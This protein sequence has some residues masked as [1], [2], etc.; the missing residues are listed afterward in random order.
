MI[1]FTTKLFLILAAT[2]LPT[3]VWGEDVQVDNTVKFGTLTDGK[4]TLVGGNTY[5]LIENITTAGYIYVPSDAAVTINLGNYHIDRGLYSEDAVANGFVI[6][7]EGTLTITGTNYV[8]I[9]GGN[10]N[11]DGGAINNTGTLTITGSVCILY[12]KSTGNG[13]G[14]SNT[15][16]VSLTNTLINNNF[17]A[18]GGG[19]YNENTLT[20]SEGEIH[21]NTATTQGG[22]IYHKTGTLDI[23]GE[24]NIYGNYVSPYTANNVYLCSGQKITITNNL[25]VGPSHRLGVTMEDVTGVFTTGLNTYGSAGL[26]TSDDSRLLS[27]ASG[28]EAKL[29]T[30]WM[31]LQEKLDAGDVILA[32]NYEYVAGI[33]NSYLTVSENRTLNLGSYKINRKLTSAITDGYVIKVTGGTLTITGTGQITG[34]NNNGNG[35]GIHIADG[36]TLLFSGGNITGNTAAN[37]GG[38]YNANSGTLNIQGG[39]I[40][41]NTATGLGG[42]VYVHASGSINMQGAPTITGNTVNSAANNVYLPTG[43]TITVDGTLSGEGKVGVTTQAVASSGTLLTSGLSTRGSYAKFSSDLDNTKYEVADKNGEAQVQTMWT[44]LQTLLTAEGEVTLTK[45]YTAIDGI[46]GPLSVTGTVTLNLNSHTINRNLSSAVTNG[47]VITNSGDLTIT[48]SGTIRGGYND[49]N[50]GGIINNGTLTI[51]GGT[52]S[53]NKASGTGGGIYHNGTAFNLS[54]NPTINGNTVNSSANNV[55]LEGAKTINISG[56]IT[57]G[58]VYI[59]YNN[60]SES[61]IFTTNLNN[62]SHHFFADVTDFGIG[63]N[64]SGEAIVGKKFTVNKSITNLGYIKFR[65]S[66]NVPSINAVQGEVVKFYLDQ[67]AAEHVPYTL[68]Y[69]PNGSTQITVPGGSYP[70]YNTDYEFDMPAQDVTITARF[71]IGWYCGDETNPHTLNDMKWVIDNGTLR[72]VTKDSDPYA[73]KAYGAGSAPWNGYNYT[74]VYLPKNITTI[75]P[76]AFCDQTRALT[77]FEVEDGGSYF[78]AVGD[79]LFSYDEGTLYCYPSGK[80][81]A[82]TYEVP[83]GVTTIA[84]GAFAYN[85]TL[86]GITVAG[87]NTSLYA[88]DGILY[89]NAKNILYC[90]PAGKI[91]TT[92]TVPLSGGYNVT[93]IKPYAFAGNSNLSFIYLLHENVP[94][95]GD[96]MFD[97]MSSSL[98][99]MVKAG[100]KTGEGKYSNTPPWSG[101]ISR[102]YELTLANAAVALSYYSVD[103]DGA[104]KT[105]G[106]TSVTSGAGDGLTLIKDTDFD[107]TYESN[108]NVGTATVRMTGINNYAGTETTKTF[109]ITRQVVINVSGDYATY[110]AAEDLQKPNNNFTISVITGVNWAD[111][112]LTTEAIDYIPREVPVIL[113]RSHSD[114][115]GTYHLEAATSTPAVTYDD[116]HFKGVL[117]PTAFTTLKPDATVRGI[118]TLKGNYFYQAT[119]GTL[120]ANRCY[121]VYL[122]VDDDYVGAPSRLSLDDDGTTNVISIENGELRI[123]NDKYYDLSGRRVLYPTKGGVYIYNGKKIVIK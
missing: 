70:V 23:S 86:N 112:S 100:L 98:K 120:P 54:G 7:N 85:T 36:G 41:N 93:T 35:G 113:N 74:S 81:S 60:V 4:Y 97:Q 3:G 61:R 44:G 22:G 52:I 48:G 59:Y 58:N 116:T 114:I 42:G 73:M 28:S 30:Y 105:P 16:N 40:Q 75:S 83:A 67:Y 2:L 88:N 31:D 99:I 24:Q 12:N 11:G 115:N 62:G 18:H 77:S 96:M 14:I 26:F 80:T 9:T 122:A 119:G 108:T 37:G 103:Y 6:K 91:G 72:F 19:I 118:Y 92:Y 71:P 84:D 17:A 45:D 68:T 87:G 21:S 79:L 107:V 20:I 1:K 65:S 34:G 121:I 123:E 5:I 32:R 111:R 89:D 95:G 49:G 38:I 76:Y 55:Y 90:Y 13:G 106:I 50:G 57:G 51:S 43:K 47:N 56:S 15:G 64:S 109:K 66:G 10:N 101:Y 46:D 27:S 104:P 8:N 110:Y 53:Y 39:T 63:L 69:N 29:Q 78:K 94:T 102:I 33:D 117:T 25:A 82:T